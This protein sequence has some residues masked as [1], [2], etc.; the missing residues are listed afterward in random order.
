MSVAMREFSAAP[1]VPRISAEDSY[2]V[3]AALST[4][5]HAYTL[6][7]GNRAFGQGFL[8]VLRP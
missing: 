7:Q 8:I 6:A 5:V 4:A 2:K 3:L 1:A